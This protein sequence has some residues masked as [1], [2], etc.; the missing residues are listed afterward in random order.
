MKILHW[1][2]EQLISCRAR[3][4]SLS[5]STTS[6]M[7]E[8]KNI[9]QSNKYFSYQSPTEGK[10]PE[11]MLKTIL[12]TSRWSSSN[13]IISLLDGTGWFTRYGHR[14]TCHV[15]LS[16]GTAVQSKRNIFTNVDKFGVTPHEQGPQ[17]QLAGHVYIW[18]LIK[19]NR[20]KGHHWEISFCWLL[21]DIITELLAKLISSI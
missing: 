7:E 19:V 8:K 20:D 16:F 9:C 12:K 15:C 14:L 5:T 1:R 10:S 3:P 6:A 4:T 18:Y 13:Q 2:T 17:P 21:I 11:K